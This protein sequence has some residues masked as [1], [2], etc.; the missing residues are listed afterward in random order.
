MNALQ[1]QLGITAKQKTFTKTIQKPKYYNR[2]KDNVLLKEN[3]N[4]MADLLFLPTTKKGFK[5][6][7]V[8]VDLA[9]DE[10]DMEP[11]TNKTPS[12]IVKAVYEINKR[13]FIKLYY[14]NGQSLRT[15]SGTE[16]RGAF[17]KWLYNHS[18]L[19]RIAQPNRHIQ[20]A[21]VERLNGILGKLLNGYMNSKEEETGKTYKEW[22]DRINFIRTKLNEV[23][24][25]KLPDNIFTHLYP[26]WNAEKMVEI[27]KN[28]KV[29]YELIKNKYK[30]GDLVYVA[31]ETPE[32]ALGQKQKGLFRN[33]DYRLTKEPH[34]IL[35]V[36][37]YHGPPY[38]RYIVNGFDGVSYQSD[39]LRPAIG[40]TDEKFKVK[41]IIG[42]KTIKKVLYYK[43]WW[44]G[45][46]KKEAT[47]EP[48][49]NLIEDGLQ[50]YIDEFN[51]HQD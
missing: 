3:F 27:K 43:V 8:I 17:S 1:E 20:L 10:F 4:F 50:A 32:N 47:F 11:M 34:K 14:D 26:T 46:P 49:Q 5:Y 41:K 6:L 31:L 29:V 38:Y 36:L 7:F 2:V 37:Y 25:K 24:K 45:Y 40:E 12:D 15:D 48:A 33:G 9:T 35:K 51:S 13:S 44:K 30:V 39:E 19:H 23:R 16:F 18:I 42:K 21:N 28:K 22:T